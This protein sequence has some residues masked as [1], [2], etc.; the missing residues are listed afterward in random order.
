MMRNLFKTLLI[1][2]AALAAGAMLAPNWVSSEARA[3]QA[4]AS[5]PV[6]ILALGDA[7]AKVR[8]AAGW[9]FPPGSSGR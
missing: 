4:Q 3:G 2:L 5:S 6:R 8:R 9:I 1:A 7:D